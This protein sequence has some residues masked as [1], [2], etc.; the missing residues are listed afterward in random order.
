M[1]RKAFAVLCLCACAG[2]YTQFAMID[3]NDPGLAPPDSTAAG[4]SAQSRIQDTVRVSNNQVCYWTRDMWGKPELRCDDS[5]YGRDWYRYNYY[6]WWSRSDPYYYGSYNSNGWDEQCPAY[7]YYDYSCGAC[8]YYSGYQGSSHSWWW[9]SPNYYGSS[10][11]ASSTSP[12]RAR[13]SRSSAVPGAG[14]SSGS[15]RKA[16]GTSAGSGSENGIIE[17]GVS[18]SPVTPNRRT[19]SD[20]VPAAGEAGR[21]SGTESRELP[22]QQVQE[23][24][25]PVPQAPVQ[26]APPAAAP[27]QN[28]D[29]GNQSGQ[30]QKPDDNQRDHRNP[31][32][33]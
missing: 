27:P 21:S 6:P 12:S 18:P 9:D 26:S 8:R 29:Q 33:W 11:G 28:T 15:L 7:Y 32:S 1:I 4:D 23:Q 16:P 17:N 10:P 2:C 25:Q 19:R 20:A 14:T 22:K 24:P 31:R 3:R 13:R 5:Y 30:N